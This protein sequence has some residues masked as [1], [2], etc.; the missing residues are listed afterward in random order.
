MMKGG[1]IYVIRQPARRRGFFSLVSSVACHVDFAIQRNLEPFVDFQTT[2]TLY[3]DGVINGSE[4][5][6]NYY[7]KPVSSINSLD[8]IGIDYV[9]SEPGF[10]PGA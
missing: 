5:A 2:T 7:F 6:W 10:P 4:N 9:V 1:N 8:E 3:N